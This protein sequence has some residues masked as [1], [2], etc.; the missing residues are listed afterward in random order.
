MAAWI[1]LTGDCGLPV[2]HDHGELLSAAQWAMVQ[3]IP[4]LKVADSTTPPANDAAGAASVVEPA[5]KPAAAPKPQDIGEKEDDPT[6][7]P[8]TRPGILGRTAG[9]GAENAQA[10]SMDQ[11]GSGNAFADFGRKLLSQ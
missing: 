8:A 6:A 2:T 3:A 10:P 11:V 9:M 1:N 4:L 5:P 7:P